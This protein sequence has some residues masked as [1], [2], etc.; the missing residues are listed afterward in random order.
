MT[1]VPQ[2]SSFYE[3]S[4]DKQPRQI[5]LDALEYIPQPGTALDIG[6]GALNETKYLL[7][8]G[9]EVTAVDSEPASARGAA[10]I[11]DKKLHFVP[12]SYEA[13]EFPK[14]HYDLAAAVYALP[15]TSPEQ[16]DG[17]VSGVLNSVKPGGVFAGHFFGEQDG[18]NDGQNKVNFVSEEKMRGFFKDFDI[19][20]LEEEKA[21]GTTATGDTKYWHVYHVIAKKRK[22]IAEQL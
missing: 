6:A 21:E 8:H 13:F 14:N 5:L 12:A 3:S 16:F 10:A 19:L 11:N 7:Q 9:F 18:W 1:E 22:A 20:S 17:V 2:W 15:F 4:K